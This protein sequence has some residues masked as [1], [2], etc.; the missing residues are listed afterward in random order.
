MKW[1]KRLDKARTQ[2]A[3]TNITK[4]KTLTKNTALQR[5]FAETE[6]SVSAISGITSR[7]YQQCTH[8]R[9]RVRNQFPVILPYNLACLVS[10]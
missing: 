3:Q 10:F 7:H 2:K 5:R 9:H 4:Q 1:K 6:T 8:H